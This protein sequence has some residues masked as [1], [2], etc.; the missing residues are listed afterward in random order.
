MSFTD[1]YLSRKMARIM[2]ISNVFESDPFIK[3]MIAY[4]FSHFYN[5]YFLLQIGIQIDILRI[6][7]PLEYCKVL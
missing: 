6:T 5:C 7:E 3:P 1:D 4:I 2:D